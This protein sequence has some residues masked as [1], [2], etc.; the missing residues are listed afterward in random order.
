MKYYIIKGKDDEIYVSHI[1]IGGKPFFQPQ[2]TWEKSE[3]AI[4]DE[5]KSKK[6]ITEI[7]KINK[8]IQFEMI[9]VKK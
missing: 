6:Y 7:N 1:L 4:Y 5:Y 3:A 8:N 2:I 9:E